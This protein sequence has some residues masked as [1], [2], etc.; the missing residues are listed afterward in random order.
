M[1]ILSF[2][3]SNNLASVAVSLNGEILSYNST[4]TSSQQ[5]ESLFKLIDLSLKQANTSL[6]Q[7]DLVALSNGPGS[8]TGIRIAISAALGME[9]ILK[10]R[11]I[12]ITNFQVVA[13][14]AWQKFKDKPICVV[15]DARNEQ[16]YLQ[17]FDL[18]LKPIGDPKLMV[19]EELMEEFKK[20]Y[21]FAGD[22][23]KLLPS[24]KIIITPSALHIANA[25]SYFYS[26]E[27]YSELKALY[28]RP[29][30]F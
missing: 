16:V 1:R 12:A 9:L 21:I 28:V 20:D 18:N 30:Y 8:F 17:K 3:T 24:S 19:C 2:D 23:L 11:I 25:C 15:L 10:A 7:L 14:H 27:H 26:N 4:D 13:W 5:A 6:D 29:N 22:G